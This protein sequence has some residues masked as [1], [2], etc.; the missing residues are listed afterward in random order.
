MTRGRDYLAFP[1]PSLSSS[2]LH[3]H[4]IYS[5]QKTSVSDCAY[6][7]RSSVPVDP[8]VSLISRDLMGF[9]MGKKMKFRKV[10]SSK[11]LSENSR[12]SFDKERQ[13]F[14]D[15]HPLSVLKSRKREE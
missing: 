10:P 12:Y 6:L 8:S 11:F 5:P 13:L 7:S 9:L 14:R 4:D 3:R 1:A 2:S 15:C